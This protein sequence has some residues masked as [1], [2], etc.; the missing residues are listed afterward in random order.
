MLRYFISDLHLQI[1]RPEITRALLHFLDTIAPEADELYLLG[2]IFEVWIGDDSDDPVIAEIE[3]AFARLSQQ[4]CRIYFMH[5]N[6]DF[7]VGEQG[8]ARLHATLLGDEHRLKL[9]QGKALLIHGDELCTDDIEYQQF[10]SMVRDTEWQ[11][12]FLDKSLEERAA[13]A[14]KLRQESKSMGAQKTAAIMDVS[15]PAV[16]NLMEQREVELLI[17]G[18]THR[19]ARHRVAQGERIVLGDWDERGWYLKAS[20]DDLE[21]VQFSPDRIA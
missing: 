16:E 11:Q 17:H 8:A 5:G 4:G 14:A 2:D 7:L 3:P 18:H 12:A 6:R 21:L 15:P 20:D 13:I 19:P 9:A 1:E 10:R